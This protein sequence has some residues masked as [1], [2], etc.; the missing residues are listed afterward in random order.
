MTT[1]T[2][3]KCLAVAVDAA[4]LRPTREQANSKR[5]RAE[6]ESKR[7]RVL[8]IAAEIRVMAEQYRARLEDRHVRKS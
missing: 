3:S 1:T 5:L 7:L 8:R 6:A 2:A 4:M